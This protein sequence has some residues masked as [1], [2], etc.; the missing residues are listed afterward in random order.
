MSNAVTE[1]H[2]LT[3]GLLKLMNKGHN[4]NQIAEKLG[5]S[6][7][8]A[9]Q[10]WQE[11][12]DNRLA[13]PF[14]HQWIL[15]LDRL[16]KLLQ[17]AHD[18]LDDEM[19]ADSVTAVLKILNEIESMQNL[20]LSRKEKA[21]QDLVQLTKQQV[22]VLFQVI[23]S[24]QAFYREELEKAFEQKTYK[25][26][27]EMLTGGYDEKFREITQKALAEVRNDEV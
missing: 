27:R 6:A 25:G 15:H 11:Y 9:H 7:Q 3:T 23:S 4:L 14:E 2:A 17:V 18:V 20:A 22:A 8:K 21:Q 16:E 19:D 5:I 10:I 12:V 24:I 1:G 26:A 13:L